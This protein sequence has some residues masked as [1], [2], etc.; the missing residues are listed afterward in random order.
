M[1]SELPFDW[2]FL[3]GVGNSGDAHWQRHWQAEHP[4]SLWLEH[5]DWDSPACEQWVAE[6][7]ALIACLQRPVVVVAHSLG[8]LLL[9]EWAA[10]HSSD[11]VLGAFMVAVPDPASVNFPQ[12]ATGFRAADQLA[13]RLRMQVITS[14][15][16][17]YGD[18]AYVQNSARSLGCAVV[19][20]GELGHINGQSQLGFWDHGHRLLQAF[21]HTL[22]Q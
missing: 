1:K 17:P 12:S 11:K 20:L 5:Q 21:A 13:C 15:N 19:S 10:R 4:N 9:L 18:L 14:T 16:D 6:M 7:Q 3:A 8:C 22:N 2:L